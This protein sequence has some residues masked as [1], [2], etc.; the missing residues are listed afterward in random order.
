MSTYK[1]GSINLAHEINTTVSSLQWLGP[2]LRDVLQLN[3]KKTQAKDPQGLLQ[4][5]ARDRRIAVK[6]LEKEDLFGEGCKEAEWRR[7]IQKMLM[8]NVKAEIQ[9]LGSGEA[10]EKWLNTK[11]RSGKAAFKKSL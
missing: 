1:Y 4:L 10:L 6:L 5:T 3:K 8:L 9:V 2:Q 7:E 11:L